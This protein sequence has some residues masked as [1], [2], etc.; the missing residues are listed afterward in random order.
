[1]AEATEELVKVF[2]EQKGYLVTTSKKVNVKTHKNSPRAELDIVGVYTKE[3][4]PHLPKR[5]VGEVKSFPIDQT[6]FE[7]LDK[8]LRSKRGYKSR[9]D[10]QRYKWINNIEYSK[11]ILIALQEEYGYDDFKFV[12]FCEGINKTYELEI[13]EFLKKKDITVITHGEILKWLFEKQG[14][15][16]TNNN[17]LQ[18][19]RL[20][21]KNAKKIDF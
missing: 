1:M 20:I 5:I 10:Y 15:E 11:Q 9:T 14:N 21:K 6:G 16:Y 19:V 4:D 3:D 2:L 17:I 13:K 8:E 12:L 18:L 7:E